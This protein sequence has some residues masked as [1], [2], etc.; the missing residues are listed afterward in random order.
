MLLDQNKVPTAPPKIELSS[1]RKDEKPAARQK[2][3]QQDKEE[4]DKNLIKKL[5]RSPAKPPLNV[6]KT[7]SCSEIKI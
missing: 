6:Q 4:L 7:E 2:R 1:Q 3:K 5:L